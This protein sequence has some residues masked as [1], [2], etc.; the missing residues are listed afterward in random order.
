MKFT[1]NMQVWGSSLLMT[2]GF[3]VFEWCLLTAYGISAGVVTL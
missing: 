3:C 1:D 2:L